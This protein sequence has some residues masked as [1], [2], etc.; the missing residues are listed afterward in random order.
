VILIL[1]FS[2]RD[3]KKE[4][5]TSLGRLLSIFIVVLLILIIVDKLPHLYS[6]ASG[7]TVYILTGRFSWIFWGFQIGLGAIIP[8]AILF[9][10]RLSKTI[11]WVAIAATSVVIGVFFERYYLVIPGAAYSQHYYPGKIE[12]VWGALPSFLLTPVETV[13]SLGMVALLGLFFML[14]LKYLELLPPR[15]QVGKAPEPTEGSVATNEG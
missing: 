3:I 5:I 10:P 2:G 11:R 13:L 4:M 15:K 14:G 12:G 1:K 9:T 7:A 8:L 6:P